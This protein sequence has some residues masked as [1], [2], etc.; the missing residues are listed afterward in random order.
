MAM[1]IPFRHFADDGSAFG[2]VRIGSLFFALCIAT[3]APP[4]SAQSITLEE[5]ARKLEAVEKRNA[6]LQAKILK[7]ESAQNAQAAQVQQQGQAVERAQ[8]TANAAS[9]ASS[10]TSWAANTTISSYGEIGYTRPTRAP[11]NAQVDVGRAVIGITHRFDDSTRMVAEFEYEHAVTSASDRGEAEVEQLYVE[12]EFKNGLRAKAG[13]YLMPVGFLN[14]THEPTAYYGVF[15]NFVE[16]AIIPT[17]WREVG[18][19]LSGTTEGALSWDVGLTTGFNLT[20]WDPAST[21]GRDGPLRATHGEGQFAA[22]RDLSAYGA[23]NWR[24]IPGL[25]LGGSVFTGKVGHKTT[26]FLANSSRL[27]LVDLHARYQFNGWDL[28]ALY[29]RATVSNTEELNTSFAV[30]TPNPTLV[31][32]RFYGGFVQAAYKLW[33]AQDYLL[34][35]FARYE[36]FNTAA[37]FGSLSTGNAGAEVRPDERVLTAGVSLRVGKGVV[38][39]TD[40]Q[41]FRTDASRDRFNIGMGYSF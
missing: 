16:T 25:H 21:E 27:T 40:Y 2:K 38:L 6:E 35:P 32:S 18:I 37:G 14:Q 26:D 9:S 23:L 4:A 39:K 22:A 31:P 15:R 3:I 36:R 33:Q 20:K 19:G 8:Q 41:K 1:E 12:R 11:Q 24:G 28:S 13:L 7:L 30:A 34:Y 5:L 17:T 10:A 29:S